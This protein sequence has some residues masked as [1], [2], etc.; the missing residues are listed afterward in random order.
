MRKVEG[1]YPRQDLNR[2]F[3]AGSGAAAWRQVL[4]RRYHSSVVRRTGI[5]FALGLP[6]FGAILL[7][8]YFGTVLLSPDDFGIFYVST[9][10]VSVLFSGS[11][12]LNLHFTRFLSSVARTRDHLSAFAA[13]R[14]I[15]RAVILCGGLCS[16]LGFLLLVGV[17]E[18]FGI[19]SRVLV[20]LIVLDTYTAYVADLG[21]TLLQSLRRAVPL[22]LYTSAWM[23]L[24]LLLCVAGMLAFRSASGALLGS[25]IAAVVIFL[26][27]RAWTGRVIAEAPPSAP[28]LPSLIALLP[29]ALGY[30]LLIAFSNIDVLM[31]YFLLSAGELARYSASAVLPKVILVVTTPV[32]QML[33]AMMVGAH[34]SARE[35]RAVARKS[36][37]VVFLLAA[38]GIGSVWLASPL[39]CGPDWG[40]RLCQP[41]TMG[42]LLLSVVPLSL[43]RVLVLLQF[44]RGSDWRALWLLGPL[45]AYVAITWFSRHRLDALA[46]ELVLWSVVGLLL[47]GGLS[48]LADFIARRRAA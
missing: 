43:L 7:V 42:L 16:A 39:V 6:G 45:F 48:Y 47:V 22:G 25:V 5:L 14:R 27:V 32:L 30:G 28:P 15:E 13:L 3:P 38:F 1:A 19:H 41:P 35:A 20:L 11:L 36:A 29:V 31:G 33:F 17:A 9:T 23:L 40:L 24:R 8:H 2:D 10:V 26:V 37:A 34:D 21:R 12:V 44:A 46:L 4:A 18:Q